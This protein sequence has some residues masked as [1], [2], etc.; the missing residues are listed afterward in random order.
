MRLPTSQSFVLHPNILRCNVADAFGDGRELNTDFRVG[1]KGGSVPK[2][3]HPPR[4]AGDAIG[5]IIRECFHF[6]LLVGNRE[7]AYMGDSQLLRDP[8]SVF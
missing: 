4:V 1:R 2:K 5:K 7:A 6:G 3:K 8:D